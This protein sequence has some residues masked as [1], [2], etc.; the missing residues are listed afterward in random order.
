[1]FNNES[2]NYTNIYN[3]TKLK[4]SNVRDSIIER[5]WIKDKKFFGDSK[6]KNIKILQVLMLSQDYAL[7]EYV[8]I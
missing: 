6:E 8:R 5:V 1:M 4:A 7:I 3:N 2:K